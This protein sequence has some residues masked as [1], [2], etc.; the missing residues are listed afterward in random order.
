[1]NTKFNWLLVVFCLLFCTSC[2]EKQT[3]YSVQFEGERSKHKWAIKDLNPD[4]PSD[5]SAYNYLTLEMNA[6]SA[7]R[8]NI[9]LYDV[10]GTRQLQIHPFQN[11]WV[12]A[13]IPLGTPNG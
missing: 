4:L 8:F 5:W 7:Q 1:M 11:A 6:S 2:K 12:R 13:S 10:E 3:S 9:Q